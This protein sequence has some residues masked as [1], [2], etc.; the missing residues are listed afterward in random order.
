MQVVDRLQ[1]IS[2]IKDLPPSALRALSL[3]AHLAY[4]TAAGA[5]FGMVRSRRDRKSTEVSVGVALGVLVWGVGWAG[6]LPVLGAQR[7]PWNQRTPRVAL[8]PIAD[9]AVFGGAWALTRRVLS[10]E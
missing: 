5:M 6:W 9:H 7:A 2:P 3:A 8:L 10:R 4:G 1:E